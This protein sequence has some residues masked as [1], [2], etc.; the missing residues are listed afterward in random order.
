MALGHI[1]E[2]HIQLFIGE[3]LGVGLGLFKKLAHNLRNFLG[4]NAKVGGNFFYTIL[5]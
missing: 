4:G 1:V 3:H 5:H 2:H